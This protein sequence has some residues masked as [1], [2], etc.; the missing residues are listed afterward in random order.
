VLQ[1]RCGL[2]PSWVKKIVET[3][4]SGSLWLIQSVIYLEFHS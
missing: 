3:S 4:I 2:S 1:Y